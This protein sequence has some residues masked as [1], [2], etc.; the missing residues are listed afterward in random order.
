MK[1]PKRQTNFLAKAIFYGILALLCFI[2]IKR[3]WAFFL[4]LLA[5][6]VLNVMF[7]IKHKDDVPFFDTLKKNL[8]FDKAKDQQAEYEKLSRKEKKLSFQ[9]HLAQIEKDFEMPEEAE[10]SDEDAEEYED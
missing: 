2:N 9:E 4:I 6:A 5:I 8:N 7:Y 10:Y 3:F 1:I